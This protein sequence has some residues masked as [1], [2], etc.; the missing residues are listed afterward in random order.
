LYVKYGEVWEGD[1][2]E[3]ECAALPIFT[4]LHFQFFEQDEEGQITDLAKN[5]DL[6]ANIHSIHDAYEGKSLRHHEEIS[7]RS[8]TPDKISMDL[9]GDLKDIFGS[10]MEYEGVYQRTSRVKTNIKFKPTTKRAI[11]PDTTK[12]ALKTNVNWI[13]FDDFTEGAEPKFCVYYGKE[14]CMQARVP[15]LSTPKA[16]NINESYNSVYKPTRLE[17]VDRPMTRKECLAKNSCLNQ[18]DKKFSR[19]YLKD[20]LTNEEKKPSLKDIYAQRVRDAESSLTIVRNQI[21]LC[22]N[23]YLE[24]GT[25][26]SYVQQHCQELGPIFKPKSNGASEASPLAPGSDA[27]N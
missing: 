7:V 23:Q 3:T 14:N 9:S 24:K 16:L 22:C 13:K 5:S 18:Y 15:R 17:Q 1:K 2:R 19:P 21:T 4:N 10:K 25:Y 20:K 8:C 12:S 26:S 11:F 6:C 27:D